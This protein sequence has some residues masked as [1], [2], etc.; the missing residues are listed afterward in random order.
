[1]SHAKVDAKADVGRSPA[2]EMKRSGIEVEHGE[3]WVNAKVDAKADEGFF[4]Q[5]NFP[6]SKQKRFVIL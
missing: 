5:P 3:V 2:T 1:M 6:F 4:L